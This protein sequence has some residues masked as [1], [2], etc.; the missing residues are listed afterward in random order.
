MQAVV[1]ALQT[2]VLLCAKFR[3]TDLERFTRDSVARPLGSARVARARE[4]A[5]ADR[6][7]IYLCAD[8]AEGGIHARWK[9]PQ[10]RSLTSK[11]L[12]LD[13]GRSAL[14]SRFTTL[15]RESIRGDV[16]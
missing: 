3:L 9:L 2:S 1:L 12:S 4:R 16:S 6:A 13:G 14:A 10:G 15:I 5:L 8:V 7:I 11:T